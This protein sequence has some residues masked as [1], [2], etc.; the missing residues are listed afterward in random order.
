MRSL[1]ECFETNVHPPP[2]DG[3]TAVAGTGWDDGRPRKV[4]LAI[5]NLAGKP[6]SVNLRIAVMDPLE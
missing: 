4:F 5:Q 6:V 1:D 2:F 3:C